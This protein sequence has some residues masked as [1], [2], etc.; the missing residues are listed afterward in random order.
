MI[1]PA[2]GPE[3]F[4]P[5]ERH[6]VQDERFNFLQVDLLDVSNRWERIDP[7]R[8]YIDPQYGADARR[9]DTLTATLGSKTPSTPKRRDRSGGVAD[10]PQSAARPAHNSK[11]VDR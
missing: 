11:A 4:D 6:D 3:D 8:L 1:V 7:L 5:L 2:F 9:Q 10:G